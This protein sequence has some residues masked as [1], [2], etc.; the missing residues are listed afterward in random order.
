M[1]KIGVIGLGH[2]GLPMALNLL[3]A[4]HQVTGFDLQT[5][6]KKPLEDAGGL[7]AND[8]IACALDQD[9]VMTMLQTGEQVKRVTLGEQGVFE[10]MKPGSLYMDCSTIDVNTAKEVHQAALKQDLLAIEAPVS[11]G[12]AGASAGTLTFMVGGSEAA[13]AAANPFLTAMG[14][15]IIHAGS[16]GS[17]QAAKM[18]NNMILGISMVAVSEAFVLA[19]QLG[20][21]PQ[22]LHEVVTHAS[23]QCW[24]MNQ[25]VPVSGILEN[26]PANRDYEPGFTVAMMLKDLCLSQQAAKTAAIKLPL[27]TCATQLYQQFYDSNHGDLDFSA[28]IQSLVE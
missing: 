4:G 1:S 3:K 20:L 16:A 23:G 25:Y 7:W 13:L 28:I 12:V 15:T 18:C 24:V 14:K 11:G 27:A 17:G 10:S 2:M 5:F 6:P 21:S 8:L 26:V 9:V 19:E 22:K